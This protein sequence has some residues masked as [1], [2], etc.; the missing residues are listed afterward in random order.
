MSLVTSIRE[1][2]TGQKEAEASQY[3]DT[4]SGIDLTNNAHFQES[5]M[6]KT[7]HIA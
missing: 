1:S 3:R 7:V 4:A 5:A 6:L 2:Y